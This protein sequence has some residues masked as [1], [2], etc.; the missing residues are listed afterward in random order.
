[1]LLLA[2][3]RLWQTPKKKNYRSLLKGNSLILGFLFRGV[4]EKEVKIRFN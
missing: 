1:M 4:A 3:D 2:G